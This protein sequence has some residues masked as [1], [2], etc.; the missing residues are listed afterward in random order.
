M[1]N[2]I[3]LY[4]LR[5]IK[6]TVQS[7]LARHVAVTNTSKGLKHKGLFLIPITCQFQLCSHPVDSKIQT[8]GAAL[9]RTCHSHGREKKEMTK[10]LASACHLL[11][12]A[13]HMAVPDVHGMG[14]C[15]S[16]TGTWNI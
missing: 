16:L 2:S 13:S 1:A 14:K 4:L 15:N 10:H 3:V 6:D 8:K 5:M 9:L 11:V 7:G 12:I